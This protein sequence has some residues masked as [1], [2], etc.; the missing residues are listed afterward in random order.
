MDGLR[1]WEWEPAR[2]VEHVDA[3][4]GRV[5][6]VF[7]PTVDVSHFLLLLLWLLSWYYLKIFSCICNK[8]LFSFQ[9]DG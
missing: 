6:D 2:C 7:I 9:I 1:L 4:W 8:V 5:G 3:G